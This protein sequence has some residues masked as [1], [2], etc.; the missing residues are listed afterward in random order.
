MS[1]SPRAS[2][3]DLVRTRGILLPGNV[4]QDFAALTGATL[5]TTVMYVA[6]TRKKPTGKITAS[7]SL[8]WR[9]CHA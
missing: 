1:A 9:V 8:S 5:L 2:F 3:Q 7:F 6:L 4:L